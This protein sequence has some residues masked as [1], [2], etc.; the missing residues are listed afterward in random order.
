MCLH[1]L[2]VTK[3]D[4]YLTRWRGVSAHTAAEML[5]QRGYGN[6][7]MDWRRPEKSPE[8]VCMSAW[9]ANMR[10]RDVGI[11]QFIGG[12][13]GQRRLIRHGTLLMFLVDRL[14]YDNVIRC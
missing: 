4:E 2:Q 11:F 9:F 10:A 3:V 13:P 14:L 12:P 7:M 6:D 1:T 8:E 5:T